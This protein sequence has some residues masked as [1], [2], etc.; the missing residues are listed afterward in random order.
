M[1]T[2]TPAQ[3]PGRRCRITSPTAPFDPPIRSRSM[4]AEQER[5]YLASQW[6]LMWWKFKRTAWRW[7]GVVSGFASTRSILIVEFL[8]PYNLHTRNVDFIYAPPQR[9]HFFHDGN[10][11]GP[12][13]YGR[14][15]TLEHGHAE[16]R[17]YTDNVRTR[18]NRSAS[19]AAA[20]ATGSGACST[21]T[22]I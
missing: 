21:A 8:A 10:F 11:V 13:V 20:T 9:V 12:F 19:S 4:T 1:T 15:T 5:I 14:T 6:R 22:S 17:I 3:R 16:A 18:S 7:S 2:S